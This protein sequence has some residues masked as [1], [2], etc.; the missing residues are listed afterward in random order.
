MADGSN[1]Y[2]KALA[3]DMRSANIFYVSSGTAENDI[4]LEKWEKLAKEVE[5]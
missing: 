3:F 2:I 5:Q 4:G 1:Y